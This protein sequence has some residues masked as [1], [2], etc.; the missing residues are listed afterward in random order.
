MQEEEEEVEEGEG[1]EE[2]EEEGGRIEKK[3]IIRKELFRFL[4][5]ILQRAKIILDEYIFLGV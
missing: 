2:V 3:K 1:E 4:W 5:F